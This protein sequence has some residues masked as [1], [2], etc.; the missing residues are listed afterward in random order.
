M[1][2]FSKKSTLKEI[3]FFEGFTDHHSH[4]LP[5]VDD[6]I[7]KIEHSLKVL[8]YYE[9][10]GVKALWCTPHIF[11]DLPNESSF[12]KER[13]A[14]LRETYKGP[15]EL[16]LAAEYMMD[17]EFQVRLSNN[18]LLP[19]GAEKDHLLVETT[20]VHAPENLGEIF[21]QIKA[22]GYYPILA[23][24]ERYRYMG[25]DDYRKWKEQDIKF[26]MNYTALGGFYGKDVQEKAIWLLENDMYN[27]CGGDLHSAHH[28]FDS[29]APLAE[30]KVKKKLAK[31]LEKLKALD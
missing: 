3:G 16:H 19:I 24:P 22:K 15:I 20:Y 4:V 25:K 23:H 30:I 9:S 14:T 11:E 10:L 31:R 26:Q 13:F 28:T 7:K 6:G 12:L 29:K 18:D 5:G 1:T 2:L 8:A 17:N 27:I 21:D